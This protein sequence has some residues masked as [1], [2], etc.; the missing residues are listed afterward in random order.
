ME[1]KRGSSIT[2]TSAVRREEGMVSVAVPPFFLAICACGVWWGSK[3]DMGMMSG[4]ACLA[5]FCCLW[6]VCMRVGSQ[7]KHGQE[8][9]LVLIVVV[10]PAAQD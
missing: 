8:S 7:H 10:L 9:V 6:F 2:G 3:S 4:G 1:L 5:C